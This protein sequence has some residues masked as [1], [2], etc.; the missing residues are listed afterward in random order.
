M[1]NIEIYV[2]TEGQ[3]EQTFVR[4]VLA[5][6]FWHKGIYLRE[7]LI[8]EPGHKGGFIY[9]KRALRDIEMF[10]RQRSDTYI[11]TM[12]DYYGID[13]AWPGVGEINEKIKQGI[14]LDIIGKAKIIEEATYKR[15]VSD[16]PGCNAEER[17]IPYF[18]MHEYEA[19]LFSDVQVLAEKTGIPLHKLKKI[20]E[21]FSS[22]EEINNDPDNAPSKRLKTL[23]PGYRKVTIGKVVSETIG[24]PTI[25]SRCAHFNDWLEK[26]E[27]L[28]GEFNS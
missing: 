12:F 14:N 11:T 13:Q 16:I 17:F 10:L 18:A 15:I 6:Y 7:F 22:P 20:R 21:Q 19:M 3:T 2:I 28:T 25:R 9:Y 23:L 4:D 24:I 1:S 27:R 5:P 8:G 26:I